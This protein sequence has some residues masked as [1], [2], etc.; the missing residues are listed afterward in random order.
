MKSAWCERKVSDSLK[1]V[2]GV[3][4]CRTALS[5]TRLRLRKRQLDLRSALGLKG[6]GSVAVFGCVVS[7]SRLARSG[8]P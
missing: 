1:G 8:N 5:K 3:A 7:P 4:P 6:S 2:G